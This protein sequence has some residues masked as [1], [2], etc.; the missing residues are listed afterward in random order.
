MTKRGLGVK[1]GKG[2]VRLF[3]RGVL[4][5]GGGL[6]HFFPPGTDNVSVWGRGGAAGR[7]GGAGYITPVLYCTYISALSFLFLSFFSVFGLS[8]VALEGIIGERKRSK[9]RLFHFKKRGTG[10]EGGY[11][12][13]CHL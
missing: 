2:A 4:L 5:E 13:A 8:K 3:V 1:R 7:G 9:Q 12:G 10:G 11:V 6:F